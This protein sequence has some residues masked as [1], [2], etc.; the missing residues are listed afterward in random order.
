VTNEDGLG[1]CL[2]QGA[3]LARHETILGVTAAPGRTRC[4]PLTTITSPGC[5][6]RGLRAIPPSS[7]QV[8][9]GGNV[10]VLFFAEHKNVLLIQVCNDG[11]VFCQAAALRSASL[12]PNP[13]KKSWR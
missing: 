11:L 1:G 13:G 4:R 6:P 3:K 5:K 8:L 7:G 9:R 2:T 12:Q 10:I